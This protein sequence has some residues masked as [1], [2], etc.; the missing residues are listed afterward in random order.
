M[1]ALLFPVITCLVT[2]IAFAETDLPSFKWK[3]RVLVV[4]APSDRDPRLLEQQATAAGAATGFSERDLLVVAETRTEGP[5]HRMFSTKVGDFQV[6]LIGKDGRSAFQCSKPVNSEILF[7]IIDKMPM[8]R[9]EIR[10]QR[11]GGAPL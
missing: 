6:A 2:M 10:Q 3:N 11:K 8:R 9:E 1:R 5:L 4:L 7:S